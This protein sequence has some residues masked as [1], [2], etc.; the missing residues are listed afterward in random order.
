MRRPAV[1]L[2]LVFLVGIGAGLNNPALSGLHGLVLLAACGA[3][4]AAATL[5][6]LQR[7]PLAGAL[8]LYVATG[9][10]GLALSTR[11]SAT[12]GPGWLA[13]R[14]GPQGACSVD[15][16]VLEDVI[17]APVDPVRRS[18]CRALLQV[19]TLW[20]GDEA[21]DIQ[22]FPLQVSLSGV[23]EILPRYGERWRV[24]GELVQ[25]K[26]SDRWRLQA[27]PYRMVRTQRAGS[28]W[29]NRMQQVRRRAA[30]ILAYGVEDLT[31]E[32][33]VVHAFLLGYRTSLP[34]SSRRTFIATGTL[35]M[36]AISGMHVAILVSLLVVVAGMCRIPKTCWCFGLAPLVM[37]YAD[38][39]GGASSALRAGVMGCVYLLAPTLGRRSDVISAL[40]LSAIL[41]LGWQPSQCF[42]VGFILSFAVVAGI[43]VLVPVLDALLLRHLQPDP[44]VPPEM[45]GRSA[46]WQVLLL[47]T[48]RMM[49]VSVAAWLTSVP[50][51]RYFFGQFSPIALVA[52]LLV[53]PLSFLIMVTGCLSVLVGSL[54]ALWLAGVFNAANIVFVRILVVGM[55]WLEKVPYGYIDNAPITMGGLVIW[56]AVLVLVAVYLRR[57]SLLALP[58]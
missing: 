46:W 43:L 40:A 2:C 53:S 37:L 58:L 57:R 54:G 56:Y 15:G 45:A 25:D 27:A 35:H 14:V 3:W 30:D 39:T 23:P 11:P 49:S 18:R 12:A 8:G 33:G 31:M 13:E 5:F 48:G 28:T 1:G 34:S 38:V 9:F 51:S 26:W 21:N 42:D 22:D 29:D 36:F 6:A 32:T 47:W 55:E 44:L 50:L 16:I 19:D 52:N 4:A 10:V 7:W 17:P 24:T 41:I 20:V